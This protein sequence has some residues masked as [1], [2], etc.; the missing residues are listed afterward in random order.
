[1]NQ[2]QTKS[3]YRKSIVAV[4]DD[5]DIASML[6]VY[7]SSLGY[8][9]HVSHRGLDGVR[10]ISKIQ[11]DLVLLDIMLPD[12]DGYEVCR[13]VRATN[14]TRDIPIVFL[15]QKDSQEDK[16]MGLQLGA[17]DYVTK[18]FD[19]EELTLRVERVLKR[20]HQRSLT[21]PRSH[22]PGRELL[23]EQVKSRNGK[24]DWSL[25]TCQIQHYAAF[26][27]AY[28]F[29]AG[30]QVLRHAAQILQEGLK[31]A[32]DAQDFLAHTDDSEFSILVNNTDNVQNIIR[33]LVVRFNET[34]KTHYSFI[35]RDRGFIIASSADG[36]QR[37]IPLM[38]LLVR[39]YRP[40]KK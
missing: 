22:L 17:V 8:E 23:E 37:Q 36:T 4:E 3:E 29:V 31:N 7:F 11:P 24:F 38:A 30:D 25:L 19:I 26:I 33:E 39:E 10:D 28:G 15:T 20:A 40:R 27:E 1:M 18:P 6:N 12:I 9:F 21:H 2:P 34:I 16:V 14:A 35:D 13:R 32:S 5:A